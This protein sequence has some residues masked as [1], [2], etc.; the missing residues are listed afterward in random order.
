M[1]KG[2]GWHVRY[3]DDPAHR[4]FRTLITE[5]AQSLSDPQINN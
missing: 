3:R 2:M 4:W 5:T 1:Q